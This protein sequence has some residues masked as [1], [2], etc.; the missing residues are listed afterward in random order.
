MIELDPAELQSCA[1][2]GVAGNFAGHLEQA[3]E[4]ADFVAVRSEV[5]APKG[6]FPW[7]LPGEAG[8]LGTFPLSSELLH[9]PQDP[10]AASVQLE[11]EAGV[12]FDVTYADG[13]VSALR[14]R[15]IG[16]F[17]DCS[18]RRAGASKISEKKNWGAASKGIAARCFPVD[19]LDPDGA[20]ANLRLACFLRREG[21]VREY[22]VDSPLPGY[23]YFGRTLIDWIVERLQNQPDDG[24]LEDVGARL[25]ACGAPDRVLVGIGAT[26]YSDFGEQNFLAAGDESIVAVYDSAAHAPADVVQAVK[27]CAEQS[28][29]SASVL[30][31]RVT[32]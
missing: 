18:Q 20:A 2:I 1:G 21:S 30:T 25:V 31:Q 15:A 22:G 9:L 17:N 29:G 7:Y 27:G 8:Q 4:S 10:D 6:I 3:G 26:R 14:P 23:S 24:P 5:G 28:L 19:E 12:L 16:A 13:K 11:P 32:S